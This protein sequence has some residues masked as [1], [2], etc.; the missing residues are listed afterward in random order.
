[1]QISTSTPILLTGA[2][3]FLGSHILKSL[4]SQ[5]LKV[6][7]T[8]ISLSDKSSYEFLYTLCPEKNS[9]LEIIEADLLSP[10]AWKTALKGIEYV[11][12]T[13]A[14]IAER[15]QEDAYKPVVKGTLNVL[16]AAVENGV[17]RI[18]MTSS[19]MVTYYGN[20][21]KVAGPE[22]WAVEEE[23]NTFVKSK[24]RAEK[25]AWQFYKENEGKIE[26]VTVLPG[27]ILGPVHGPCPTETS[28]KLIAD[29]LSNKL[30]G[31]SKVSWPIVDV[32]DVAECH[33]RALRCEKSNGKRYICSAS[34]VWMDNIASI[35]R[36][37]FSKY[38]YI[39]SRHLLTK[40]E[41]VVAAL[42]EE[43]TPEGLADI[44]VERLVDNELSVKDLG[45]KYENPEKTLIE[46]GYSLIK[47][48]MI[49]DRISPGSEC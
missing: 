25:A 13:A 28:E 12:H 33:I 49:K 38:G 29:M 34:S 6:R 17:K 16:N 27:F 21:G 44:G 24:L 40:S 22:D 35:M 4:L 39:I 5:N 37:E 48:G 3:S 23:C 42:V 19:A 10:D 15:D 43:K 9:N 2:N 11:I 18:V 41:I 1:M 30:A 31:I 46:M 47:T 8:I 20:E 26:L 36:E 14:I 32:R 45:I 7:A